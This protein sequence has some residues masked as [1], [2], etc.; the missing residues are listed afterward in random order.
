MLSFLWH[1]IKAFRYLLPY[2]HEVSDERYCQDDSDLLRAKR[3]RELIKMIL[4]RF[5]FF[6]LFGSMIFWVVVPLHTRNAVL[7]QELQ[8]RDTRIVILQR[9]IREVRNTNHY[10]EKEIEHL[11][12]DNE[13]NEEEMNRIRFEFSDCRE[14]NKRLKVPLTLDAAKPKKGKDNKGKDPPTP[15][16]MLPADV[17]SKLRRL[18]DE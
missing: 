7:T 5:I 1:L 3:I 15:L 11:R 17:R 12:I 2:L 18:T 10:L 9:E 16:Q 8:N 13:N 6:G 14:E 4:W